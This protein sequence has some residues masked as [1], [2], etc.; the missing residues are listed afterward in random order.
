M[1]RFLSLLLAA[2][3]LF[4]LVPVSAP[5]ETAAELDFTLHNSND[6]ET[7][8][9]PVLDADAETGLDLKKGDKSVFYVVLPDDVSCAAVCMKLS[10]APV[11]AELQAL[12]SK[13]KWETFSSVSDP[14]PAFALPAGSHSGKLRIQL[15]FF[16][17]A[18]CRVEELRCLSAGEV[19][20]SLALW[21]KEE[22]VDILL[23]AESLDTVDTALLSSLLETGCSVTVVSLS[24][25]EAP[26]DSY[27]RLWDAGLR[28]APGVFRTKSKKP[29]RAAALVSMIRAFQPLLLVTD[30]YSSA[31]A[32]EAV[33]GAPDYSFD[34]ESAAASGLWV[35]PVVCEAGQALSKAVSLP[36]RSYDA[37]RSA[38]A[39]EFAPAQHS[40]PSLIPYPAS[41]LEDGYLPE[42]EA[43]FVY[44]DPDNG[45]W[46]Y[47]SQSLQVEIVRYIMEKPS[48]R[49]FEAYVT[50][51]PDQESFGQHIYV[52]ANFKGQQI[53][54]ETLAQTSKLVFAINGDYYPKRV[55]NK[56][57]IGNI[58]RQRQVLYNYDPARKQKYPNQDCAA[59]R[60]DGS[61]SVYA[62]SEISA[63]DLLAQGDVHDVLSFGPYLARNGKIRIYNGN[64]AEVDE[65]RTSFGMIEP[66][67][68]LF[69]TAEGKLPAPDSHGI[70]L[71][72]LA[73]L[74]YARGV[75]DAFNTDGGNT[76]V[77]LFMGHKLN[78]TGYA[79]QSV[80]TP[81]NQHELFGIGESDL[82]YTDMADGKKK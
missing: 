31:F 20:D 71:R 33:A 7:D 75:T 34:I 79:N 63:D 23:T 56:E 81:R 76:S 5:A 77:M 41:R 38:C 68:L 64:S 80:G 51:K 78:R 26:A 72:T 13:K 61:V 52:N 37:V 53:Y 74:L 57:G 49:W 67:K 3:L 54:P 65:P 50:F 4:S 35:V 60:D 18:A 39:A 19:P 12:S 36:E 55:D 28:T 1:N 21:R 17:A 40:D 2:V 59:L 45:L 43:E 73:K 10:A 70:D 16:S 30:D 58:I 32:G 46:A 8:A 15:T 25:A 6:R 9:A 82:V 48:R 24:G 29:D 22:Q 27:S 44:D 42:G 66:G 11:L 69:V 47:L 14:G 62:G